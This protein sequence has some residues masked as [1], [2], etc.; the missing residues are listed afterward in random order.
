MGAWGGLT[1]QNANDTEVLQCM[2]EEAGAF[3]FVCNAEMSSSTLDVISR[4]G[5]EAAISNL[6]ELGV[7]LVLEG[8]TVEGKEMVEN[9]LSILKEKKNQ[10]A[11]EGFRVH[12][13][14]VTH[15]D[16]LQKIKLAKEKEIPVSV[17]ISPHYLF[18]GNKNATGNALLNVQP[19]IG[20]AVNLKTLENA[21][22]NK[23]IDLIA[24]DHLPSTPR[25]K[26][27]S[28]QASLGITGLQYLLPVTWTVLSESSASQKDLVLVH[29]L[30]STHPAKL[31]RLE[32]SKG[33]I[34]EGFDA[35]LVV[36]SILSFRA[37]HGV[38]LGLGS[39]GQSGHKRKRKQ[40]AFSRDF[41]IFRCAF[42]WFCQS[43]LVTRKSRFRS[44]LGLVAWNVSKSLWSWFLGENEG[45]GISAN[46]L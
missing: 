34:A 46:F 43:H 9:V 5:L 24:S 30:L 2:V 22:R 38:F 4:R 37:S 23:E 3:G 18:F 8:G 12:F 1:D 19:P 16:I 10:K 15:S 27:H 21:V 35:D 28:S 40:N 25:E 45:F 42:E 33:T 29:Q 39:R 20:N 13:Q 6:K 17:E 26:F 36:L 44:K 41:A 7:A 11:K 32:S 31:L 14:K